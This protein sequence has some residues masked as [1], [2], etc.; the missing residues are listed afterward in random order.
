MLPTLSARVD[1]TR[2]ACYSWGRRYLIRGGLVGGD[3]APASAPRIWPLIPLE[4][5]LLAAIGCR[6]L[7]YHSDN[8][9]FNLQVGR[10][11][12][13]GPAHLSKE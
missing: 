10:F 13:H 5:Q 2:C 1:K 4:Q 12:V 8:R 7:Q 3:R 9:E 6:P 11:P